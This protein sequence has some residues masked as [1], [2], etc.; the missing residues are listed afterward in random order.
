MRYGVFG[1]KCLVC[2]LYCLFVAFDWGDS[3]DMWF[4]LGFLLV[5]LIS[6]LVLLVIC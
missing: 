6:L 1:F 3:I 5:I 4:F 2:T